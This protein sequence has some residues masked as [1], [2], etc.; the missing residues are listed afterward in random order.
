MTAQGGVVLGRSG[1]LLRARLPGDAS[2]LR[3]LADSAA[4]AGIGAVPV[5]LKMP[6]SLRERALS[7]SHDDVPVWITLMDDDPEGRWRAAL[8][9]LGAVVGYFDPAIRTYAAN[10]PLDALWSVASADYVLAVEAIGRVA[11]TLEMASAAM[12]AD[13]LRSYN[14]STGLFAGIGGASVAVG[15]MD[16]GLNVDHRDIGSNRRSI[17]GANFTNLIFSR[18]ED[19][20]LWFDFNGHGTHVAGIAF[21]NGAVESNRAGMAPLV[22]DI[23]MAKVLST[24]GGA[25]ALGWGRAMDWFA[26]P[27]ACG[28]GV[29]RKALVIN[30]SV[31]VTH[32]A[33]EGRSVV[34]RKIDAAVWG[35]RQLFVTS[36]GNALDQGT[37]SMAGA[38]N[39]L[40][41]GATGNS[42]DI[43]EFSSL[44]PTYDGRLLPKVVGT[45]V[46]VAAP[47]GEGSRTGYAVRSG[48]SMASPSVVGVAALAMD[49][50]PTLK[51]EPAALRA[52]LMASAIKP[53]AFLA[54][55]HGFPPNNTTGPG[56]HGR[57]RSWDPARHRASGTG[58]R[59]RHPETGGSRSTGRT[60]SWPHIPATAS[61]S[62]GWSRACRHRKHF[63]RRRQVPYTGSRL[64]RSMPTS[65]ARSSNWIGRRPSV[66]IPSAT[67]SGRRHA[68]SAISRSCPW[69]WMP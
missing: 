4:V 54:D 14:A 32:A 7:G 38:K 19:Q 65:P 35:A 64:H 12:G 6:A 44:G 60:S 29:P 69:T 22:Q 26:T 2:R 8:G 39:A 63:S 30:S 16:S 23:R 56:T 36:A 37:S 68:R 52:H 57:R 49:A 28:D 11:P 50:V 13:A 20:D 47:E 59:P 9:D 53:D 17:C 5:D 33:W 10:L 42:G 61:G 58:G 48:T 1:N 21:G 45:G 31:G 15:V 41:V 27:T 24:W 25:S 18:E 43:A 55:A 62:R 67:T 46:E 66:A 51:E 3:E 40:S 34:E